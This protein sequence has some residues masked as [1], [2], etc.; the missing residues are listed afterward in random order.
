[1]I[2]WDIATDEN[3]QP[4]MIEAN[5][6]NGELDFHQLC[7]GPLFGDDAPKILKKVFSKK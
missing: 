4:I 2:S 3:G 1:M 5:L 6:T 7:N